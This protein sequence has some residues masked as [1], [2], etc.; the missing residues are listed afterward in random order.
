MSAS[1]LLRSLVLALLL[2]L[3]ACG[4]KLRGVQQLP[5]DSIY[6]DM[7]AYSEFA[8]SIK[9]QIQA[10]GSRVTERREDAQVRL[11]V[12]QDAREKHI[13][14]L[15][16]SGTVREY[17]L[18]QRFG[19]RLIDAHGRELMP[20][21]EIYVFRDISFNDNQ[22]LAKEQE[23][24]LLYRD[25]ENDVVTQLLRRLGKA[26]APQPAPADATSAPAAT[27]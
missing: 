15:N 3:A 6:L 20:L 17:Q 2:S 12:V 18:R 1:T 7:N 24:V 4:F 16:T 8:A 13:L 19:F 21:N 5:F 9:R 14:T 27:K 11:V 25:M 23:E 10:N 22:T 26:P